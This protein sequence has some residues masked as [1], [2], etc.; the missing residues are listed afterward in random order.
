MP[1]GKGTYGKKR[2]RPKK[3]KVKPLIPKN[4]NFTFFKPVDWN[5]PFRNGN[6]YGIK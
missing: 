6:L 4:L 1:R 2:G 5:P 3:S